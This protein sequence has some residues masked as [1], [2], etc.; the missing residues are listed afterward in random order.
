[1]PR[2]SFHT[3]FAYELVGEVIHLTGNLDLAAV[4][5]QWK[6]LLTL[7]RNYR[8]SVLW[9][10]LRQV[11]RLDSAGAIALQHLQALATTQRIRSHLQGAS[12]EI[13][14]TLEV[15]ALTGEPPA[16]PVP[17]PFWEGF[18]ESLIQFFLRRLPEFFFLV[19]DIA[20][21]SVTDLFKRKTHRQGEFINQ[22]VLI[23][24]NALPI[25]AMVSFLIGFVLSLQSAEQLRQ[26]G[27]DVF[28][29]DLVVISMTREMGPLITAILLAGRSGSAICS[30]IA[31]MVVTEEID[32]LKTMA[33]NP[34]RFVIIPK[35]HASLFALPLLTLMANILGILGGVF[36]AFLYLDLAPNVF[37]NRMVEVL[38]LRDLYTGF[39][40]SLTFAGIIVVTASYFGLHVEGGSEGVGRVTTQAVVTTIFL[41]I[42]ADSIL[43]ILFY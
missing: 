27:A 21:W 11:D 1:M 28:I 6:K 23:G 4:D 9:L 40:K 36:I 43:G 15:F 16:M 22:A 30:E 31:T 41:V 18:G 8:G 29:A 10:D 5:S 25:V 42:L 17:Q 2:S 20:V 13:Q 3:P 38:F 32:A 34:V 19:A 12:P 33:L 14:R 37:Y 39:V 24:V 7:V 35:M 26:F